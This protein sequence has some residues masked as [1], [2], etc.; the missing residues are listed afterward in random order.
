M[1]ERFFFRS[2]PLKVLEKFKLWTFL[3][4][5]TLR[6]TETGFLASTRYDKQTCLFYKGSPFSQACAVSNVTRDI[7]VTSN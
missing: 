1:L 6:D 2:V 5:N 4:L 3:R 7:R